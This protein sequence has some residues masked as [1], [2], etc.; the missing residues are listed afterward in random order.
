MSMIANST[1]HS[2]HV[3]FKEFR[4]LDTYITT[5]R[6]TLVAFSY[7]SNI[8]LDI[9]Y[10]VMYTSVRHTLSHTVDV[11]TLFGFKSFH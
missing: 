10:L 7:P 8:F 4:L 1:I 5:L 3:D 11:M 2:I 9:T 6:C